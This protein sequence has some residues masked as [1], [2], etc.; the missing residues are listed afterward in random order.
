MRRLALILAA[1]ILLLVA[2][3]AWISKS[4]NPHRRISPGMSREAAEQAVAD[5]WRERVA[6]ERSLLEVAWAEKAVTAQGKTLRWLEQRFGEKP[7]DGW[8]LF[9]SLHGGGGAPA[10]VNDQQWR[11]QIRLYQHPGSIFVAPRAPTDT[12]N[13]WHEAHVDGLLDRLIAAAVVTQGV[14]PNRVYLLGY[15][16]G[17]D[18]VYQLGPRM[19]D[20]F[21]AASMMAGHP[22]EASPLGLRN[23]PFAIWCG[24]EDTAYNRNRIAGEWLAKLGELAAADPGGYVH[25][26]KV[27]PGKGHWMDLED[28]AALP[29]MASFTRDPWP[30]TLVWRQDDVTSRRFYWLSMPDGIR[31]KPGDVVRAR[32]TSQ[33]I[34]IESK[35]VNGITLRLSDR[36]VDLDQPVVIRVNGQVLCD[37]RIPRRPEDARRSLEDR[38]DPE[39]AATAE[40]SLGW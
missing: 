35:D 28:R 16:A 19:A 40:V 33:L 39:L 26:G 37:T 14:N 12:W 4:A 30:K 6:A 18:G 9:I 27:V 8:N 7:A 31:P 36:L 11:N 10:R 25:S 15:S 21:A 5:A 3:A 24:A 20:R 29:W 13:L 17:G 34:E 23:L 38:L 32:V 22:N 2:G 1:L